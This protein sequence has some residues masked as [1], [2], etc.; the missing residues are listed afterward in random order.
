MGMDRFTEMTI[1]NNAP[2]V[3]ASEIEIAADPEIVWDVMT[4]IDRWPTWNPDIEEVFLDGEVA[5][6]SEFRWKSGP[7]MIK[8][9]IR[10]MER[11]RF[12][13]WT[14][15]TLGIKAIHIWRMEPQDGHTLVRT[16]ESWEGFVVRMFR[17]RMQKTLENAI[18]AGLRYLKVEAE[19]RSTP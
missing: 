6:G 17:G 15:K 12:L 16:E 13:A 8:S 10:H 5:E 3:A 18:N 19:R 14:G 2:A 7:G 11:A 9:T 4:K 1:N